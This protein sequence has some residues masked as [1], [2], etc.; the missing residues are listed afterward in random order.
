MNRDFFLY[1]NTKIQMVEIQ[2]SKYRNTEHRNE[3]YQTQKYQVEKNPEIQ[4]QNRK[5]KYHLLFKSHL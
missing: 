3:E 5:N 1:K 4:L 2:K